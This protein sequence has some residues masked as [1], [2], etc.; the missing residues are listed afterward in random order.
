MGPLL[1]HNKNIKIMD[2]TIK[3]V[4]IKRYESE[5]ESVYKKLHEYFERQQNVFYDMK[6]KDS[7]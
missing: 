3:T 4:A 5:L 6:R 1:L 2:S 7:W